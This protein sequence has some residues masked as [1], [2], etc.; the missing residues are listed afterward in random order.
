MGE[1]LWL[2]ADA[3]IDLARDRYAR[4]T[5]PE[6]TVPALWVMAEFRSLVA[7]DPGLRH[8]L[9]EEPVVAMRLLLDAHGWVQPRIVARQAELFAVDV[10]N[11]ALAPVVDLGTLSY[12]VV[13]L[14]EAF[15][16]ADTVA[17]G[18][19]DLQAATTLINALVTAR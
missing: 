17:S 12:A 5:H 13:R 8:L 18:T 4:T 19:A 10:A 1:A 14:S 9:T 2:L 3:T 16:Y 7:H 6:G 15:L 11:G